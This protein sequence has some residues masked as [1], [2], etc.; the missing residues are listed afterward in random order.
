MFPVDPEQYFTTS[1][2]VLSSQSQVC[3]API[4]SCSSLTCSA[5]K[6]ALAYIFPSLHFTSERGR[7]ERKRGARKANLSDPFFVS[8]VCSQGSGTTDGS[9]RG[10]RG[11]ES[12]NS[13]RLAVGGGENNELRCWHKSKSGSWGGDLSLCC[14]KAKTSSKGKEVLLWYVSQKKGNS[15]M[16]HGITC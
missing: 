8:W 3:A 9:A 16:F 5:A 2:M 7:M 14:I 10:V 13:V 1:E 4:R 11:F 6:N 15:H 12:I